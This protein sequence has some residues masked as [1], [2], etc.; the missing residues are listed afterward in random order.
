MV[1]PS[2]RQKTQF[3]SDLPS[4]L[5]QG[6]G[7]PGEKASKA[8]K[9]RIPLPKAKRGSSLN[10]HRTTKTSSGVDFAD[11]TKPGAETGR[12]ETPTGTAGDSTA[13]SKRSNVTGGRFDDGGEPMAR[14]A[15]EFLPSASQDFGDKVK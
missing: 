7:L 15:T 13:F 1:T 14:P 12:A 11:G 5:L 8:G 2:A 4:D 9:P 10:P 6:M 3:N